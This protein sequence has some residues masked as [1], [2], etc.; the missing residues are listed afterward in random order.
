MSILL[1]FVLCALHSVGENADLKSL[2]VS[3]NAVEY[4]ITFYKPQT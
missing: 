3:N 4:F 1:Y 2:R